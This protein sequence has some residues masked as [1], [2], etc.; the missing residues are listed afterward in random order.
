MGTKRYQEQPSGSNLCGAYAIAYWLKEKNFE[1]DDVVQ[2]AEGLY[3][4]FRFKEEDF[5]SGEI[6]EFVMGYCNPAR[7]MMWMLSKKNIICNFYLGNDKKIDELYQGL[8]I[9]DDIKK[10]VLR[11]PF[12]TEK[13]SNE[14]AGLEIVKNKGGGLHYLYVYR[15][16]KM[17]K[18]IDPGDGCLYDR[19]ELVGIRYYVTGAGIIIG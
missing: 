9:S 11:E 16:S 1:C 19:D 15:E 4:E 6:C 8:V 5:I 18:A 2:T 14:Q 10:H 13:F 12:S 7:I 17:E 3:E